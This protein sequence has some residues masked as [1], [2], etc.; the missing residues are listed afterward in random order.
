MLHLAFQR[1]YIIG[2][3]MCPAS[4]RYLFLVIQIDTSILLSNQVELNPGP[5]SLDDSNY[6]CSLFVPKNVHGILM[7]LHVTTVTNC[8]LLYVLTQVHPC[9][10]NMEMLQFFGFAQYVIH[11]TILEQYFN[12]T[13]PQGIHFFVQT[14]ITC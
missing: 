7:Q 13:Y 14:H 8:V 12:H 11:Q 6:P 5:Q 4:K 3:C 9:A 10:K 1:R 2:I